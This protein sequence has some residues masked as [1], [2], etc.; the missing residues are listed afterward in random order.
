MLEQDQK[1]EE[2]VKKVIKHYTTE[3]GA[4]KVLN[5]LLRSSK[6]CTE[7][8]YCQP[9]FQ[10]L[11]NAVYS[12]YKSYRK[13]NN[14]TFICYRGATA[15]EKEI[16]YYENNVGDI[17]QTLGFLSTSRKKR[18]AER[19]AGNLMLMITVKDA[20][21][22]QG[23]DFGYADITKYSTKDEEEIL[24]NPLNTF[25]ITKV[26]KVK[27]QRDLEYDQENAP[28]ITLVQLEYG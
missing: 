28:I 3:S 13:K 21:R 23:L 4:Y 1:F 14:R 19:F 12:L 27:M 17:I 20:D 24:F 11:L 6:D 5:K 8:F 18:I 7:L 15:S 22:N 25:K 2:T 9:Y 16:N 26:S 10:K